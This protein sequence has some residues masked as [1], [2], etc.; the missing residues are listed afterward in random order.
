[1][2]LL[3]P[4]TLTTALT[5][6][7]PTSQV[8]LNAQPRNLTIQ[9]ALTYVSGGTTTDV[10]VQTTLDGGV[11]WTDIANFHFTTSSARKIVN[12]TARTPVTSQ[13]TPGDGAMSSNTAQ[14]GVLGPL[15]RTKVTT[16]GTYSG[17]TSLRVDVHSDQIASYPA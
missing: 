13:V 1:M 7:V 10:Y 8:A 2:Q 16:T 4:L 9:A 15:F 14:D 12:L 5:A 17:G 3:P 11:T 6:Y